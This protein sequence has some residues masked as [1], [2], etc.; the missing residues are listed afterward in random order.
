MSSGRIQNLSFWLSRCFSNCARE[1]QTTRIDRSGGMASRRVAEPEFSSSQI[2]QNAHQGTGRD[3]RPL[4]ENE[5]VAKKLFPQTRVEVV[6]YGIERGTFSCRDQR[7]AN[8][9]VLSLGNDRNRDWESA[10]KA[11]GNQ[12]GI[13]LTI[14]SNTAKAHLTSGANNVLY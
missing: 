5:A 11:L 7:R 12:D 10:I 4:A 6:L 8:R 3:D 14:V 13:Y 9:K 2:L 1:K